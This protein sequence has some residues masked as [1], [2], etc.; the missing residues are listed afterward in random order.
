MVYGPTWTN[1]QTAQRDGGSSRFLLQVGSK[2]A[3]LWTLLLL[4][5]LPTEC[6]LR[7]CLRGGRLCSCRYSQADVHW[8]RRY[9][10]LPLV[11]LVG[12]EDGV[13]GGQSLRGRGRGAGRGR[14]RGG[15]GVRAE[16]EA[17]ERVRTCEKC[18]ISCTGS[19]AALIH[20]GQCHYYRATTT[21]PASATA[22]VQSIS[23]GAPYRTITLP[24]PRRLAPPPLTAPPPPRRIE[25]N[26]PLTAPP[27]PLVQSNGVPH[28]LTAPP[29]THTHT[30]EWNDPLTAPSPL[31]QPNGVRPLLSPLPCPPQP[32]LQRPLDVVSLAHP[33]QYH[34]IPA[35]QVVLQGVAH[36]SVAPVDPVVHYLKAVAGA[37]A[38]SSGSRQQAIA[39]RSTSRQ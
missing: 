11:T 20:G 36:I 39:G 21:V 5:L 19:A 4:L 22:S 15:G 30:V 33:R 2:Q 1:G 37:A 12:E 26:D 28:S 9:S 34:V 14:G 27:P 32:Y 35:M 6:H 25:W 18:E 13:A 38:D 17:G 31:A 10:P 24:M 3:R 16:Q 7:Y 23:E 8:R 29:P